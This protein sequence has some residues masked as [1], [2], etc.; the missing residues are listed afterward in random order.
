MFVQDNWKVTPK[1][2]LNLGM[3]W[4][5]ELP[6]TE[7]F[8]RME[9]GFDP[10]STPSYAGAAQSAY[11]ATGFASNAAAIAASGVSGDPAA[12]AEV[13]NILSTFPSTLSVQGGY[14]YASPSNRG[15]WQTDW[16]QFLPRFG[17]AYAA[18]S[19]TVVRGGFGIFYDALGV[20]RN[21]LPVQDGYSRGTNQPSSLDN[22]Q[23]FVSSL[24]SPFPSG[25][26]QP[27]GSSLG[28]DLSAGNSIYTGYAP[29]VTEPYSMHWSF[30]IQRELPGKFVLDANYVAS[31][32][33]HLETWTGGCAGNGIPCMNV[34]NLPRQYLSNSPTYDQTN[35]DILNA[36]VP[37]PY[38]NLPQFNGTQGQ[39]TTLGQLLTPYSQY[40][41]V[42]ETVT[43]GSAFYNSLQARVERRFSS[44]FTIATNLTW[45]NSM[46]NINYLNATDPSPVHET[47]YAPSL[48]FNTMMVYELPVGKNKHF[49]NSWH[50]PL[51]WALGEWQVSG[52]FRA[53]NGYPAALT[54][55]LLNP[56]YTLA[57]LNG[58]RDPVNFFNVAAL[59]T[60]SCGSARWGPY[61]NASD[62]SQL[63]AWSGLLG[64]GWSHRQ[65]GDDQ[66]ENQRRVSL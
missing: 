1:L 45:S 11:A 15:M 21:S 50:G 17:F 65:E 58:Q 42:G 2:T 63:P 5:L 26:L 37:N 7:R 6:T 48:T 13:Q 49:G 28:A 3:R 43:N 23:T 30:G 46:Q 53:Q 33:V 8:N 27:V 64:H 62:R 47:A 10:T 19:K 18:D 16:K 52:T 41:S 35:L 32:S 66:G 24:A 38:Y 29:N 55:L 44:G 57:D 60:D 22:G 25:L 51:N 40:G 34:N 59:N 20:G 4:E 9:I 56:G 61:Q 54:D 31:R 39:T 36:L 14:L 12:Q